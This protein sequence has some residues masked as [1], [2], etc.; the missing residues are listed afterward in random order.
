MAEGEGELG[1]LRG[2]GRFHDVEVGVAGTRAPDLDQDLPRPRLGHRHLTEL[3]RLLPLDELECLHGY[4]PASFTRP[5]APDG[6]AGVKADPSGDLS[7]SRIPSMSTRTC[8]G[9]RNTW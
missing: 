2:R 6:S 7:Q 4:S 5:N 8:R 1:R 9:P 3:G